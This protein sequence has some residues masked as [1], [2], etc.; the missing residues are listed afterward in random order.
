MSNSLKEQALLFKGDYLIADAQQEVCGYGIGT[1]WDP[2]CQVGFF[3]QSTSLILEN[4][5]R[6]G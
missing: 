5:L 3:N 2:I 1:T 6:D 4:V